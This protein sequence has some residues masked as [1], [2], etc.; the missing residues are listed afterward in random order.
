MIN[1]ILTMASQSEEV[2]DIDYAD[3][4][5]DDNS[6]DDHS[7]SGVGSSSN[8]TPTS[9]NANGNNSNGN[10]K[11]SSY[12]LAGTETRQVFWSRTAFLLVLCVATGATA[13]AVY[14]LSRQDEQSSFEVRF[15]DFANQIIEVSQ[16]NARDIFGV[17]ESMSLHITTFTESQDSEWPEVYV[18]GFEAQAQQAIAAT[19]SIT[20][21]I[22]PLVTHAQKTSYEQYQVNNYE[23]WTRESLEYAGSNRTIELI[24][25]VF[26]IGPNS[27]LVF[28][29]DLELYAP[30]AYVAPIHTIGGLINFE[31]FSLTY[32]RRVYEEMA[33]SRTAVLSEIINLNTEEV[34]DE[35]DWPR[36]FM[37]APIF[38][39]TVGPGST[40]KT[41]TIV[42]VL[43]A[44]IPWHNYFLNLIPEGI[45][46][47]YLVVR[48]TC[49][50]AFTFL[51][52]GPDVI[53]VGPGELHDRSFEELEVSAQFTSFKSLEECVYN[54]HLYPSQAFRNSYKTT[55]PIMNTV[56]V[57]AVFIL[58]AI[59]FL[60]YDQLVERRQ[61][62]VLTSAQ[63]SHAIVSSLFPDNVRARMMNNESEHHHGKHGKLDGF[64]MSST[65]D[66]N[67]NKLHSSTSTRSRK[68]SPIADFFP[69]CSVLFS[70]VVG[71][72]AWSS[73]REPAEVFTLLETVYN[74]FDKIAVRLK[75]FKVETIGDCYVAAC[76]LPE[77]RDD[78]AVLL[79]R[80]ARQC[81]TKMNALVH[82]LA[83]TLGP[84]TAELSMRFGIHSGPVTAGVLRGEKSRF[85]LFG[86][87]VN[88]AARMES[89]GAPN[90]IHL[91]QDTV[92]ELS[93]FGKQHWFRPR[94]DTVTPKG[95]GEMKTY[96]GVLKGEASTDSPLVSNESDS[97]SDVLEP[98]PMNKVAQKEQDL[99]NHV[100]W[101]AKA[102]EQGLKKILATISADEQ[103]QQ[104]SSMR[105]DDASNELMAHFFT[106]QCVDEVKEYIEFPTEPRPFVRDPRMVKLDPVVKKQLYNFVRTVARMY[107][108]VAY[109]SFAHASH[110]VQAVQ[111]QFARRMVTDSTD[112][113]WCQQLTAD[114][115]VPFA[116]LFAALI[117]D[118]DHLG[119]S[120]F[121]LIR[122]KHTIAT[123]YNNKSVAEQNS[124]DVAWNLLMESEFAELRSCIADT[125]ERFLYFRQL[126]VQIVLATDVMDRESNQQRMR[127]WEMATTAIAAAASDA[128]SAGTPT[129]TAVSEAT[130][131]SSSN[132]ANLRA[133]VALEYMIQTCDVIHTMQHWQ[134]YIKWNERLFRECYKSYHD[135]NVETDPCKGWYEGELQFFDKF[136]IPLA[137][138]SSLSDEYIHFAHANRKE[139]ELRG[140]EVL[141]GY[142]MT[143][144][145]DKSSEGE[146]SV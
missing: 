13:A 136:V 39:K 145:A 146:S 21:G 104:P 114:P 127:R 141:Q 50:Q 88:T 14:L 71:F 59:F 53:Y 135:G 67:N 73:T 113:Q 121:V 92:N 41:Q 28:P 140:R 34:E 26:S 7:S 9:N 94:E 20:L 116:C 125:T 44:Q 96:W 89:S 139:W 142:L 122:Q 128:E 6:T 49:D 2:L 43:T 30:A 118:V 24:P 47:I 107:R 120:N 112:S 40:D 102:L 15:N 42:A 36:S 74:A 138:R 51:I 31:S 62:K 126:V 1:R 133:T 22:T 80:F 129:T 69:N 65:K 134:T 55:E 58:T 33:S 17:F 130:D 52:E 99:D 98:T 46:G 78:H 111:T 95:K 18:P 45:D 76:G 105:P 100:K 97:I 8:A 32:F 72:T 90:R 110:V 83:N 25:H 61:T 16:I 48:N 117:H 75:I 79:F 37:A 108:N 109:H 70:D 91:S 93:R 68:S 115:M 106:G 144:I 86:D 11:Q 35:S 103:Q 19:G 12:Q 4:E 54:F 3:E 143:Y 81:L 10:D 23:K 85:Q 5:D 123:T 56:V 119:V 66:S 77:S 84:D 38:D 131:S 101:T 57:T 82:K 132:H 27:T 124:I 29:D 63:K 64:R 60:V 137:E 87:T